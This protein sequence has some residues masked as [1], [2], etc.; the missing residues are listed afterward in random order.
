[1]S[2]R[3][4]IVPVTGIP[5]IAAGDRLGELVAAALERRGE[6]LADTDV[7]CV[8]QKIVSKAEGRTRRLADVQPGAEAARL[9]TELEKDPRLVEL[10]LTES[11]R[12]VRAD[13]G[14]LITE[15]SH[16]WICANA[17]IDS[18]NVEGEGVVTLLPLDADDSARRLR[19]E[20]AEAGGIRPAVL[21]SDSFGRPWRVGQTEVA[22]GC[23]GLAP[24]DDWRGRRDLTGR[25]LAATV[26]AIADELAAAADLSRDKVSAVPA[27]LVRGAGRHRTDADGP[28]AAVLRRAAADDLFR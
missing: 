26:I 15:T 13:R 22:I 19:A 8:A 23:A 10:I 3:I 18:S 1:M 6:T 27:V 9:A 24:V 21:I 17:G 25:E 14:V 2:E 11:T 20:I 28:G 5:E 16:G 4:E 12:V 7:L